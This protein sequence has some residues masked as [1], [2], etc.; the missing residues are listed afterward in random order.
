MSLEVGLLATAFVAPNFSQGGWATSDFAN[1]LT[2][3]NP[4]E[5]FMLPA[6]VTANSIE[7]GLAN[8]AVVPEPF[9]GALLGVG[10]FLTL[11]R[12]RTQRC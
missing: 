11:V 5:V 3:A 1:T 10:L 4:S 8:N 2:L 9:S 7:M 12:R 6:G